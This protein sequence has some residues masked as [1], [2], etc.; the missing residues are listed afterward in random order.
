VKKSVKSDV[1]VVSYLLGSI[2]VVASIAVAMNIP[3]WSAAFFIYEIVLIIIFILM[4][5]FGLIFKG[6]FPDT[7]S[8]QGL[9][10]IILSDFSGFRAYCA[11]L[12]VSVSFIYNS[13]HG[14]FGYIIFPVVFISFVFLMGIPRV[15]KQEPLD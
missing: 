11:S 14:G 5:G 12:V 13:L 9:W 4:G 7:F 3:Y 10:L 15:V 8:R 6:A 2:V 1:D